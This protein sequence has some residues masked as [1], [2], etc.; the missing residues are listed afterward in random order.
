MPA[1]G[2]AWRVLG[3]A[4]LVA[5]VAAC[6]WSGWRAYDYR[7]AVREARAAGFD[8]RE[9]PTPFVAIRADW[10]AALRPAT[11]TQRQR[12]LLLPAGTDLAPLRPLLLRLDPTDLTVVR[13]RQVDAL[14]GLTRLR[15]LS[16]SGSDVKGL[17]PLAGV[18]RLKQLWLHDCTGVADLTPLASLAQLQ[19]L[20]LNGSPGVADLTPLAGL[21]QL[22]ALYFIR[23]PGVTDL[24]PLAGLAHLH[25]LD[26]AGCSG[27]SA[28]AVA[29]FKKG[30]PQVEVTNPDERSR[31]V[32]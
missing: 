10:R 30:H 27:L 25:T 23:C 9:S 29:V 3:W 1:R 22:Q 11:W 7:A 4:M 28:E 21:A 18:A 5:V 2:G 31:N 16:L 32:P 8:F 26:L 14:R 15:N 12:R 17:A 20:Y 13:C 19:V 24:T 6:G